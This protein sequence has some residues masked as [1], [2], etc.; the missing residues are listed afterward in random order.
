MLNLKVKLLFRC[1]PI[2]LQMVCLAIYKAIIVRKK[3]DSPDHFPLNYINKLNLPIFG[4]SSKI[5]YF[6]R[7]Y[8]EKRENYNFLPES[9]FNYKYEIIYGAHKNGS[10][11]IQDLKT[12]ALV[13]LCL[14]SESSTL[15]VKNNTTNEENLLKNLPE[16]RFHYFKINKGENYKFTSDSQNGFLIG[17]PI[18]LNQKVQH[19]KKLVLCIFIDGLADSSQIESFNEDYLMPNTVKFFSKGVSFKNN[20]TN[21]EWTLPSVPSF[22]SGGRQQSHGFYHPKAKHII[23]EDFKI[24]SE[25]FHDNEYLTFQ[26]N[27]NWRVSPAYGYIKGFDR[28][29]YKK[30]MNIGEVT[31]SFF[32]H[33]RTF[34]ER[35]NFVWLTLMDVHHLINVIPDISNQKVNSTS[36]HRV[37]PWHEKNNNEKS[38]FVS[39]N[40]DLTE[41]YANEI[42]RVDYYLKSIYDF[43]ENNYK[44]EEFIVS[45]VSDHGHAFL[46]NDQNPISIART[47]VPWM[48]RGGDIPHQKSY[49]LTENVDFFSSIL[50]CSDITTENDS[51]DSICPKVLGGTEVRDFVISQS[52]Y[53]GQTYKA[54]VRDKFF[55]Y[56]FESVKLVSPNGK[57]IGDLNFNKSRPLN[58]LNEDDGLLN[59]DKYKKIIKTKVYEWNIRESH[60]IEE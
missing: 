32:E 34:K 59:V 23:G 38:V 56:E 27:G 12:D 54:I 40:K 51:F 41:I 45:L 3:Y 26:A 48:I 30:E 20:F 16:Q 36:A 21:A 37:T 5:G 57:I 6:Y 43:V 4:T 9:F 42:K 31:Q 60:N 18:A 29:I 49:E 22:F 24:I 50:K 39:S 14:E 10:Q 52:I 55:E 2:R 7:Y 58:S 47:K 13:P 33:M 28:T 46:T 44:D 17:N 1:F 15:A 25:I 53:P 8:Q 11:T 19:D 35:D